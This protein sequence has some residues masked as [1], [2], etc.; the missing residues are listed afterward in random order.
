MDWLATGNGKQS[1][2]YKFSDVA[3]QFCLMIKNLFGLAF[4]QASGM[5]ASLL[6]LSNLD[7]STPVYSTHCRRQ[8]R[9]PVCITYFLIPINCIFWSIARA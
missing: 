6:K 7:W 2:A 8:Q 1:R 9:L 5:V 4:R 3:I